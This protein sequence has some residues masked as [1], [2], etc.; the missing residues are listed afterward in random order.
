MSFSPF[1]LNCLL[2]G[3]RSSLLGTY[4]TKCSTPACYSVENILKRAETVLRLYAKEVIYECEK[5]KRTET[6][7]LTKYSLL[8]RC[9][10]SILQTQKVGGESLVSAFHNLP[11]N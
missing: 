5:Q 4:Q 10:Y 6:G 11:Y 2:V 8:L 7:E 1:W 3:S 9:N